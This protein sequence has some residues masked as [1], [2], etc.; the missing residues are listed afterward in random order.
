MVLWVERGRHEGQP[1]APDLPSSRGPAPPP[2][3]GGRHWNL[4]S[5]GY[6]TVVGVEA[7]S[8]DDEKEPAASLMIQWPPCRPC[9]ESPCIYA[10][11]YTVPRC[12]CPWPRPEPASHS[13]PG[14]HPVYIR[15]VY[16]I[17]QLQRPA[18][19][20]RRH[21]PRPSSRPSFASCAGL[22][23]RRGFCLGCGR[24]L[25]GEAGAL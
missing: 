19:M 6:S 5:L 18:A 21:G 15:I 4:S 16:L 24:Q 22:M 10:A 1:L 20:Q 9:S 3:G 25:A 12:T 11:C 2:G 8:E 23:V 14:L 7:K 13:R 17:E